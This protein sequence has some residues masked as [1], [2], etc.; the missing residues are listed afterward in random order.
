ME[1]IGEYALWTGI[2]PEMEDSVMIVV[3]CIEDMNLSQLTG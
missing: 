3:E 2:G 1:A